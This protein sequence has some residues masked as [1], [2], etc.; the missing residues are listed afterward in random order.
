MIYSVKRLGEVKVNYIRPQ[1]AQAPA[2]R[3][4]SYAITVM[5]EL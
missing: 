2:V 4:L 3:W 5:A 1:A